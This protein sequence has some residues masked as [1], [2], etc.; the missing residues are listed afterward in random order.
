MSSSCIKGLD[1]TCTP[2]NRLIAMTETVLERFQVTEV[3]PRQRRSC[4]RSS[5]AIVIATSNTATANLPP[6]AASA[7]AGESV[8]FHWASLGDRTLG[9]CVAEMFPAAPLPFSI[10]AAPVSFVP[11][12]PHHSHR[13]AHQALSSLPSLPPLPWLMT[14]QPPAAAFT[15][16]K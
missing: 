3:S 12:P 13:H 8:F 6:Q 11:S 15:A 5:V 1:L 9:L 10:P 16:S 14:S 2:T 7:A 4:D